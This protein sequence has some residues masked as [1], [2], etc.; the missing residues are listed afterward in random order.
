MDDLLL[1]STPLA[2]A[3]LL[4]AR[5]GATLQTLKDCRPTARG[6]CSTSGFVLTVERAR[7]FVHIW[8]WRKE[9]PRFRCQAP[10]KLTCVTCTSDGAHAVAG[11]MSGKLYL[12]Q[13]AS[14]RLLLAWDAHFKPVTV[15]DFAL[16]DGFLLSAG[17]DAI[18]LAWNMAN[19][20]NAARTRQDGLTPFRTWSEHML[21]IGALCVA[22]CAQ[23]D[24]IASASADQTVRVWRLSDSA[25]TCV[26]HATF[27]TALTAVGAHPGH[28]SLYAGGLTYGSTGSL[29]A[30]FKKFAEA[31]GEADATEATPRHMGCVPC[32]L[33][34]DASAATW[35][36]PTADDELPLL[37]TLPAGWRVETG[38]LVSAGLGDGGRM[39]AAEA[40]IRQLRG[41]LAQLQEVNRELYAIA[42]DATIGMA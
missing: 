32:A 40:T 10:E 38:A 26:H 37:A 12:W 42:A 33:P 25:R 8:S 6:L 41:Q 28:T 36:A 30:P 39:A 35:L 24:L 15:L 4:D 9:Q 23:H 21:P 18:L 31:A 13:V 5:T 14:G 27:P 22:P 3:S 1:C 16:A 17:E 11:G 19:L 20:L 2:T 34:L 7:S 29:L